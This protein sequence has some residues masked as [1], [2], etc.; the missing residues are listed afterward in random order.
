MDVGKVGEKEM[1]EITT[2][3][4]AWMMGLFL[5]CSGG[6]AQGGVTWKN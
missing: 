6:A 4:N 2:L 1:R 5:R 3:G